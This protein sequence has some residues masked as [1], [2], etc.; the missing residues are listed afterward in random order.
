VILLPPFF[1]ASDWALRRAM[2]QK[3][4]ILFDLD[5][6]L[7]SSLDSVERSWSKWAKMRGVDPTQTCKTAHGCRAIETIARCARIWTVWPS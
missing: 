5:G 3:L 6:I 2:L 1:A 4:G 7:I